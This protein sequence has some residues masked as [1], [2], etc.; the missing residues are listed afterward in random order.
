MLNGTMDIVNRLGNFHVDAFIL[1]TGYFGIKNSRKAFAKTLKVMVFYLLVTNVASVISGGSFDWFKV[2]NPIQEE[3]WWFMCNY[4]YLI[5]LAPYI[6]MVLDSFSTRSQW[7][8]ILGIALLFDC[9]FCWFLFEP[10][11]NFYGHNLTTFIV[12]YVVGRFLNSEYSKD[13]LIR[14]RTIGGGNFLGSF[15]VSL[16]FVV[17]ASVINH[18]LG[19]ELRIPDYNSPFTLLMGVT[20]FLMFK[21]WTLKSAR[22][23]IWL[24]ESA[25]GV[26]LLHSN[27]VFGKYIEQ[28]FYE[29]LMHIGS[30]N[31]LQLIY[32]FCFAVILY[33]SFA[34]IDK[35]RILIFKFIPKN[36]CIGNRL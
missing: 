17:I 20:V 36:S 12:M 26:Y 11:L 2:L 33:I 32:P 16:L 29:G 9:Y 19:L 24:S 22:W 27:P 8:K 1:I 30:A 15:C 25:I 31:T 28:M 18:Y 13:F 4:V 7:Y 21:E 34:A 6:N 10:K 5:L 35:L 23:I 14:L 3:P